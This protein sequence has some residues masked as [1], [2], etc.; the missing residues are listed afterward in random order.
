[1]SGMLKAGEALMV[2][3]RGTGP[4]HGPWRFLEDDG[5]WTGEQMVAITDLSAMAL[6]PTLPVGY[7]TSKVGAD[8]EIHAFSLTGSGMLSEKSSS[9]AEPCHLT[10]DPS[11]RLLIVTNYTTST[12]GLQPLDSDGAFS[13]EIALKK[14]SGGGPEADRQDDAHPHQA[15][16]IG[17]TLVVIDLGADL[18]REFRLDFGQSGADML[19]ALRE[20][21]MPAGSGPRHG[22]A[23]ADGRLAISGELGSN[24]L[25]GRL[26]EPVDNWSNVHSTTRTGPAKT[27]HTRN[28][29]G[30]IQRSKDGRHVYFANR[31]YDT[32]ACFD[33][34]TG[35]PR[36][37]AEQDATVAWAQ[38]MLVLDTH[39]LVAGW[40]SS[41][42]V[43]LPLT[44][45]VPGPAEK[46]LQCSGAAWVT[47]LPA[48]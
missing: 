17:D 25:V 43:C 20:T 12:L 44:D 9:G 48:R 39:L 47:L 11:G 29:P 38:H 1:M 42:V 5:K 18:V 19:V 26:G 8:G 46:L 13:G 24:L 34:S 27:R 31:G 3:S 6:H 15:F 37:V 10:V 32:I 7:A 45:G 41:E 23:L 14:L 21:A 28:Y 33:V 16:F 40:D 35:E 30:D 22:V 36:L 2:A 4:E